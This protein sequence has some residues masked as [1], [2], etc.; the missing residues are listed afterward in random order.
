[1]LIS[2]LRPRRPLRESFVSPSSSARAMREGG[3]GKRSVQSH[4][5]PETSESDQVNVKKELKF[6]RDEFTKPKPNDF[7]KRNIPFRKGFSKNVPYINW[8]RN[9]Q[10]RVSEH[11]T[12]GLCVSCKSHLCT[13]NAPSQESVGSVV[14]PKKQEQPAE[15]IIEG[16]FQGEA[17]AGHEISM[18][19]DHISDDLSEKTLAGSDEETILG[20][21]AE[22]RR[23]EASTEPDER[24]ETDDRTSIEDSEGGISTLTKGNS[25]TEDANEAVAPDTT[26][27]S[28]SSQASTERGAST[29]ELSEI[30][31][32]GEVGVEK[33]EKLKPKSE[34]EELD[35]IEQ[36][37]ILLAVVIF[38]WTS[39]RDFFVDSKYFL[40]KCT[41]PDSHGMALSR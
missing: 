11:L 12:K 10:K 21:V 39:I 3:L 38:F 27:S 22:L 20:F 25:K 14:E 29:V 19:N 30:K 17:S 6:K 40:S 32:S 4:T 2:N 41:L 23:I 1:M 26:I 36:E 9:A 28:A 31:H 24:E 8:R 13:G 33:A 5:L 35:E 18:I 34:K 37:N 15:D 7:K 16:R